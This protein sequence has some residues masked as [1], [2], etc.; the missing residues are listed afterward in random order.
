MKWYLMVLKNY[1]GFKGR[2]RRKEFWMF[3]LISLI[4]SY[5]LIALVFVDPSLSFVNIIYSLAVL[6]PSLAVAARR[7]HDVGKSG[8]FYLIPFYNLYLL[9]INGEVGENKY[10][11]DPK[12]GVSFNNEALDSHL[13]N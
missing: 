5:S 2:A 10:G 1:A 7:M 9:C 11:P 3:N 4:I 6:V 12:N 8:W 13:T